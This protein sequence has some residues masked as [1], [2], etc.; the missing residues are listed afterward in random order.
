MRVEANVAQTLEN[1][2]TSIIVG[3]S[4]QLVEPPKIMPKVSAYH[5]IMLDYHSEL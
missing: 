3:A 2:R 4:L 1:A 5:H